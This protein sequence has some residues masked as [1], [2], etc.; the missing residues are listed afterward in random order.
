MKKRNKKPKSSL[1]IYILGNLL[2]MLVVILFSIDMIN[3]TYD[4]FAKKPDTVCIL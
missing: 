2:A 1:V 3:I 4:H